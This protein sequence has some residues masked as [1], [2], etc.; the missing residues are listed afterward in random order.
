MKPLRIL[1]RCDVKGKNLIKGLQFEGVRVIGDPWKHASKYYSSGI[2][3]IL[4][5]DSVASLYE[6]N[7]LFDLVKNSTKNIFVPISIGG[8]IRNIEDAR[9]A[10]YAGAEKIIINTAAIENPLLIKNLS[11]EFGRQCIVLSIQAKKRGSTWEAF[12]HYGRESSGLDALEWLK[13]ATDLGAGEAFVTSIDKDGSL[14]GPDITLAEAA[15]DSVEIPV[16]ISGGIGSINEIFTIANN[17]K[18]S[19]IALGLALHKSQ[20]KI[21]EI[22]S[23]LSSKGIKVRV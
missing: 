2:D 4:Y 18:V 22:K 10:L 21:Q 17:T 3:E 1:S 15:S 12:T 14:Q 13:K 19:G 11:Q 16:I 5:I 9:K 7:S 23:A 6:R 8:G 20:L